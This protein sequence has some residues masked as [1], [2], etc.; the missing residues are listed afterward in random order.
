MTTG[1]DNLDR[2]DMQD[3]IRTIVRRIEIDASRI[4]VI[5]RAR[6]Q[7]STATK[8]ADQ[9]DRFLATLYRRWSR[10][11][12]HGSVAIAVWRATSNATQPPS[13]RSSASP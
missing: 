8:I 10:G 6:H 5:F 7:M 9:N 12:S 1:L 4:E 11:R 3:I 2:T 13:P